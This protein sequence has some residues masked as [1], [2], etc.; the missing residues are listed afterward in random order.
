[1]K[2]CCL[3][4][5]EFPY[6]TYTQLPACLEDHCC[7]DKREQHVEDKAL[8][9]KCWLPICK[10]CKSHLSDGKLPP[11][12]YANDMWTGYGLEQLYTQQVTAME[13]TCSSPCIPAMQLFHMKRTERHAR[14]FDEQAHIPRHRYGAR[15]NVITFP[16]PLEELFQKLAEHIKEQGSGEGQLPRNGA[17]LADVFKVILKTN[18]HGKTTEDEF[19][20][21]IH[22][23]T[24]RRQA[25]RKNTKPT[26]FGQC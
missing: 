21:L 25:S 14:L 19:K 2:V 10:H 24:V 4:I 6:A 22:Q 13:L 7:D 5:A 9:Q 3:C 12:S 17:Q 16:L 8:C 1:M 26:S 23:A 11:L 15:G 18:K 20:S